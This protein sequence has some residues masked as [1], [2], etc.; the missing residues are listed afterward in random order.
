MIAR[1]PSEAGKARIMD[2]ESLSPTIEWC[3]CGKVDPTYR[4]GGHNTTGMVAWLILRGSIL[5]K[6][7]EGAQNVAAGNWIVFR[8]G[9]HE[10]DMT[11]DT[12]LIS[13]SLK[14]G[15]AG[16]RSL[17]REGPPVVFAASSCPLLQRQA[18]KL[19][20]FL[21]KTFGRT[22][23]FLLTTE[24]TLPVYMHL[25]SLFTDWLATLVETLSARNVPHT[26]QGNMDERVRRGL[27]FLD[28][29]PLERPFPQAEL[30][31]SIA[32]S[33][34]QID[35]LFV[36]ATGHTPRSYFDQRRATH[37]RLA[38]A[39][40]NLTVKELAFSLGFRSISHFSTWFRRFEGMSPSAFAANRL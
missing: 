2:W 21:K 1:P 26:R 6:T 38:L 4:H 13:I 39:N 36:K 30:A 14:A 18:Q 11:D 5:L 7:A 3:Y 25:Q 28:N 23:T 8:P 19:V 32:L 37:A 35:R 17:Y 20:R 34:S 31:Q 12:T 27:F 40:G 22:G 15:W 16:Q 10:R 9:W 33:P 29:F 24:T